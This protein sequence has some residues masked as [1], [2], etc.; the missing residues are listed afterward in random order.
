M[1]SVHGQIQSKWN[2]RKVALLERHK[3]SATVSLKINASGFLI[4][5]KLVRKSGLVEFDKSLL[6]AIGAAAPFAPPAPEIRSFL[7]KKGMEILFRKRIFRRGLLKNKLKYKGTT[8]APKWKPKKFKVSPRP[9]PRP[10]QS[11][12]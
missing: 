12:K 5:S 7:K 6:A 4:E 9:R 8:V 11:K 2:L 3:R 10:R 1:N